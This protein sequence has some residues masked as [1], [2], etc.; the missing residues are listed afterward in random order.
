MCT[1]SRRR[2]KLE[3]RVQIS[4][5][6][7]AA[8]CDT[9]LLTAA[10]LEPVT[11]AC[12]SWG[13]PK[14]RGCVTLRSPQ[15]HMQQVFSVLSPSAGGVCACRCG[16]SHSA[17]SGLQTEPQRYL[18]RQSITQLAWCPLMGLQPWHPACSHTL[19]WATLSWTTGG[20]E[21]GLTGSGYTARESIEQEWHTAPLLGFL[22]RDGVQPEQWQSDLFTASPSAHCS[23]LWFWIKE[24]FSALFLMVIYTFKA[25]FSRLCNQNCQN[26]K[27]S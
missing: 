11:A 17:G 1:E 2:L 10:V 8:D 16:Y 21:A 26:R 9:L 6:N 22:I 3:G 5:G 14:L 24:I 25:A 23:P 15:V 18:C 7:K 19:L 12:R 20:M 27:L 4:R 13:H